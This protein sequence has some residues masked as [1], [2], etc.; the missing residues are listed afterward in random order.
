M[1][2]L[3]HFYVVF[4]R[5]N[6]N[7]VEEFADPGTAAERIDPG[8]LESKWL[9]AAPP[10]FSLPA[11]L[12]G[13]P[14]VMRFPSPG[15]SLFGIV[16]FPPHS[17]GKRRFTA[18]QGSDPNMRSGIHAEPS[19]HAT[20]TLDYDVILSGKIDLELGNGK[21][22]TI[23]PGT[24]VIL[25]GVAHAWKNHYDEPCILA[26]IMLGTDRVDR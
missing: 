8:A 22:R 9:W 13:A 20:N 11:N 18:D 24:C 1:D 12:G 5:A 4:A 21:V 17:A 25:G 10:D 3:K 16:C 6:E 14:E 2:Y 26:N 7:G 19:M 23:G 15:A